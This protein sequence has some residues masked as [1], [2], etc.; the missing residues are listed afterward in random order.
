MSEPHNI[1]V[2]R[3]EFAS[4]LANRY[5]SSA[6]RRRWVQLV[7]RRR[8]SRASTLARTIIVNNFVSY[9]RPPIRPLHLA[10]T[11][12][13]AAFALWETT[14]RLNSRLDPGES[15]LDNQRV[16]LHRV[17]STMRS[18]EI[19]ARQGGLLLHATTL[20]TLPGMPGIRLRN[21]S[22]RRVSHVPVPVP[23]LML[24]WMQARATNVTTTNART[25]WADSL[26]RLIQSSI[27]RMYEIRQ[28]R[29]RHDISHVT[30]PPL[31]PL[32]G[33]VAWRS[34]TTMRSHLILR[35]RGGD[36]RTAFCFSTPRQRRFGTEPSY[37]R[38]S[39]S[40]PSS[41]SRGTL[42]TALTEL[43]W[44]VWSKFWS[45]IHIA[46]AATAQTDSEFTSRQFESVLL[47]KQ[48]Q[49]SWR[50]LFGFFGHQTLRV[51]SHT[52]RSL[53]DAIG[54]L[55]V[56]HRGGQTHADR[57]PRSDSLRARVSSRH[58]VPAAGKMRA[59]G[60]FSFVGVRSDHF[61]NLV[62]AALHRSF[63]RTNSASVQSHVTAHDT[64]SSSA[65]HS[66]KHGRDLGTIHRKAS[67]SAG[68]RQRMMALSGFVRVFQ[69]LASTRVNAA[70]DVNLAKRTDFRNYAN[71]AN[72][73]SYANH[74]NH[75]NRAN[76]ANHTNGL[77]VTDRFMRRSRNSHT[78]RL[79]VSSTRSNRETASLALSG[80]RE[81]SAKDASRTRMRA[82]VPAG[83]SRRAAT[84]SWRQPADTVST[85]RASDQVT[86]FVHRG[87]APPSM[88][89]HS[90]AAAPIQ[91]PSFDIRRLTDQVYEMIE[92]KFRA[93]RIRR[94]L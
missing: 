74:T 93:E 58:S 6:A 48:T 61:H 62:T 87:A 31:R 19:R 27:E 33:G 41:E 55:P 85:Q 89:T 26:S 14:I 16:S 94:G 37:Y 68:S 36:Q 44:R 21:T 65:K 82:D 28:Q 78:S 29:D 30:T 15:R 56:I 75:T 7:F 5:R 25:S 49:L 4:R 71:Y 45:R 72:Q 22:Q 83:M 47:R 3:V 70:S 43:A 24:M 54:F 2:S 60:S 88:T 76:Q 81:A 42:V 12:R 69:H 79:I 59:P 23:L 77:L 9:G 66:T 8:L 17:L 39:R 34:T 18:R 51:L 1:L 46:E 91:M 80:G 64:K 67:A 63:S 73:A 40:L 35:S 86:Q 52:R 10:I 13:L 50:G 57:R 32:R 90:G 38:R 84:L 11:L 20:P 53:R 92:R